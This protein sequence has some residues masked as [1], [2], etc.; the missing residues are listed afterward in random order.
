MG[1]RKRHGFPEGPSISKPHK[2]TGLIASPSKELLRNIDPGDLTA[3]PLAGGRLDA[4]R[5]RLVRNFYSELPDNLSIYQEIVEEVTYDFSLNE[6]FIIISQTIPDDRTFVV[7][8]VYFFARALFGTGLVPAGDIEGAVQPYFQIG[9]SIPVEISTT[10]VQPGL[11]IENRA[12]FPFLN[13]R[14]GAREANFSIFA[15]RGRNLTAYYINRAF[16][17]IPLS[18]IGIRIEGWMVDANAVEEILG[19]QR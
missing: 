7:D 6:R 8:N 14:I 4:D 19:Q 17:T 2:G 15:K 1:G 13:D 5:V 12:Y 10:R 16:T 9:N 18:T 3:K 11:P